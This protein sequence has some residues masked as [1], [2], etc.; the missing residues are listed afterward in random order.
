M[1]NN[2]A[3]IIAR[4]AIKALLKDSAS[5]LTEDDAFRLIRDKILEDILEVE[6]ELKVARRGLGRSR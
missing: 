3:D 4:A 6:N 2:H 1:N 5:I